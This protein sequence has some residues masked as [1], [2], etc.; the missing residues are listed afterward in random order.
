MTILAAVAE[1][2]VSLVSERIKT[3]LAVKRLA[4]KESGSNWRSGRPSVMTPEITLKVL[5]LREAKLSIRQIEKA[6]DRKISR[7]SIERILRAHSERVK[8]YPSKVP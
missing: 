3:A 8:K 1:L 7:A 6:L 2:E 5:E 4:A